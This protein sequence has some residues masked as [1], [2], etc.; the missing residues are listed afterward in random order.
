M[1]RFLG[2]L[3]LSLCPL[4]VWADEYRSFVRPAELRTPDGEVTSEMIDLFAGCGQVGLEV[5]VQDGQ[6]IG[7]LTESVK[8]AARSRLK[9]ARLYKEPPGPVS[10]ILEVNVFIL[11]DG[12]VFVHNTEFKKIRF[13]EMTDSYVMS[14]TGWN[15]LRFGTRGKDANYVLSSLSRSF[16]VFMDDYLRVNSDEACKPIPRKATLGEP[17]DFDPFDGVD[18]WAEDESDSTHKKEDS[19]RKLPPM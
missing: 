10:G 11:P 13:D 16:D 12:P 18:P 5:Y 6:E 14:P 15:Q 4:Y 7:L 8:I 3:L 2:C 9:S 17:V 19:H 1:R